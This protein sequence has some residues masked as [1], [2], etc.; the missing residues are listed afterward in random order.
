MTDCY[1]YTMKC[2]CVAFGMDGKTQKPCCITHAG[3]IDGEGDDLGRTIAK[4]QPDLTGRRARCSY[5]HTAEDDD[6]NKLRR[7]RGW[8]A[9]Q[10]EADSSIKLPFFEWRGEGSFRAVTMCR[11]CSFYGSAH[12]EENR[13]KNK[14]ICSH[15]EPHGDYEFDQYYC[16]CMGWD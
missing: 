9:C 11:H 15:F 8:S 7:Q 1:E 3:F 12:T 5:S 13:K 10:I 6:T 2:G 16:G 14:R 4:K